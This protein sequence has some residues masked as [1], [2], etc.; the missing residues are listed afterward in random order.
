[1]QKLVFPVLLG[2]SV[3]AAAMTAQADDSH[4][5][6]GVLNI[7]VIGDMPYGLNNADTVQFKATPAFINAIN[8]DTDVSLVLHL[9]DIHSGKQ[10]CSY[11]YNQSIY[12]LWTSAPGFK[13]PVIYTPGDNEWTDCHKPK[14][15]VST[16]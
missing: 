1:M 7:A 11:G 10:T 4:R 8:A 3:L 12:D 9:G 15:G 14:E 5:R 16:R 13:S 6:D 2:A